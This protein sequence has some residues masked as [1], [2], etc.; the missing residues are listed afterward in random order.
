MKNFRCSARQPSNIRQEYLR[1]MAQNSKTAFIH[2]L[3][4]PLSSNPED[5]K[6]RIKKKMIDESSQTLRKK[7]KD[8]TNQELTELM[9]HFYREK[10][11]ALM[12]L[13]EMRVRLPI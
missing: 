10:E 1:N 7:A 6:T 13:D 5:L 4:V 12:E 3:T 2:S 11:A 9:V 8:M